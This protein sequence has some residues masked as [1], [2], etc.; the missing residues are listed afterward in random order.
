MGVK[1]Y[2]NVFQLIFDKGER[3]IERRND[4]LLTNSARTITYPY[5]KDERT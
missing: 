5:I 3:A 1:K 4:S 2:L